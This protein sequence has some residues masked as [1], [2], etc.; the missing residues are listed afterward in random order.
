MKSSMFFAL[1]YTLAETGNT[2]DFSF[3]F[4]FNYL[5]FY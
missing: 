3:D 2:S 5:K 4:Y 1:M